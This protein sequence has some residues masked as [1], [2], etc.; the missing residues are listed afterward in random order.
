MTLAVIG[1]SGLDR[2]DDEYTCKEES[3][4]QETPFGDHSVG[5]H[6][7]SC[8]NNRFVFLPRHGGEH[9]SPPHNVNYRANLWLLH[10]L[11]IKKIIACNVVGGITEK[12]APGTLVLPHQL[13]DY[14]YG[15][16]HTFYD[17]INNHMPGVQH[18][19]FTNPYTESL[20]CAVADFFQQEGIA[21]VKGGVYACTQGPRLETAAEINK[22]K[23]DGCDIV[24]MTAMP[25]A[26]L[27]R[28]LNIEY[29]SLSL[30]V[31]WAPGVQDEE[32]SMDAIMQLIDEE[33]S[34]VS[35]F[36]PKL[37]TFLALDH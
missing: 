30:V 14:T 6:Y 1:G 25:E 2:F 9:Q 4:I 36:L 7:F 34:K 3:I 24:G 19:D 20:R 16:Q 22:L 37:L 13:I 35:H 11:G 5:S 8:D 28:E 26:A 10:S 18:I 21:H 31:N 33:I 27:A 15:R 23:K 12:M 17:G 32:L 29:V